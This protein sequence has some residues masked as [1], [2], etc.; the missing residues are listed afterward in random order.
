MK[1][2]TKLIGI[3]AVLA[4]IFT[5]F[6]G[7]ERK[8]EPKA[9]SVETTTDALYGLEAIQDA[10]DTASNAL[11]GSMDEV[12]KAFDEVGN[13]LGDSMDEVQKALDEAQKEA[14]DAVNDALQAIPSIPSLGF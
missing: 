1:E 2:G 11:G 3:I 7:C 4:L 10:F 8:E 12:Q 9:A 14:L 6:S 5:V 13:I